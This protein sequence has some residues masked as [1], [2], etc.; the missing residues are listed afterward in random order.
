MR[1]DLLLVGLADEPLDIPDDDDEPI[2]IVDE[3][4]PRRPE[5]VIELEANSRV[6]DAAPSQRA[7]V[8]RVSR[9]FSTDSL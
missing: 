5:P 9:S 7:M 1:R 8:S 3:P 2:G 6:E 4:A